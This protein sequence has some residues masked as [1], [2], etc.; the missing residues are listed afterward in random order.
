MNV[1][2]TAADYT[3]LREALHALRHNRSQ[4]ANFFARTQQGT[5]QTRTLVAVGDSILAIDTLDHQLRELHAQASGGLA[6]QHG[7]TDLDSVSGR[8]PPL[9][10]DQQAQEANVRG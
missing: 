10:L 9:T 2:L 1:P 5:E 8:Y 4:M 7:N 6:I 3:L